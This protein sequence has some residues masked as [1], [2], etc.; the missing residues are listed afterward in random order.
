MNIKG[1]NQSV[2]ESFRL[3][4]GAGDRW[5]FSTNLGSVTAYPAFPVRG[6]PY[7]VWGIANV[8]LS[9][10]G[11]YMRRVIDHR[12]FMTQ[13]GGDQDG[14]VAFYTKE[15][16]SVDEAILIYEADLDAL[17]RA[18]DNARTRC[19]KDFDIDE[20]VPPVRRVDGAEVSY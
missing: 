16:R 20:D 18:E 3:R 12:E 19:R 4:G 1:F 14:Y 15:H 7:P 6:M 11:E 13:R 2:V 10:T 17:R 8:K 9:R 5:V